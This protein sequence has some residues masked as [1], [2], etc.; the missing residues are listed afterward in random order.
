MKKL[1]IIGVVVF[2]ASCYSGG[3]NTTNGILVRGVRAYNLRACNSHSD[4]NY[5]TT[6]EYFQEVIDRHTLATDEAKAY[7]Y[8]YLA[9]IKLKKSDV[10]NAVA[11]LDKA[12][13]LSGNF[14]YKYEILAD[15][16]YEKE[17]IN[18]S[19]KYYR[20]LVEWLSDRIN[21]VKLGKF[22]ILKLEFF[23]SYSY[24]S[25]QNIRQYLDMYNPK[26]KRLERENAYLKYLLSRKNFAQAQLVNCKNQMP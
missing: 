16:F 8:M 10:E 25:R 11:L 18:N 20:L 3:S 4:V 22:D 13:K 15:Y 6:E 19:E 24:V 23:T 14:P 2:L 1:L 12:D 26:L 9:K 17:D 21:A 5:E 7:A